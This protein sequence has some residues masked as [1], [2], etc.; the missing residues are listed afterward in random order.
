MDYWKKSLPNMYKQ[1]PEP[2]I[3]IGENG[4]IL[5][6]N[7]A[8]KKYQ[9]EAIRD[10]LP[11]ARL[12][13]L[14][15]ITEEE[16]A[17]LEQFLSR[18]DGTCSERHF[19]Y[20]DDLDGEVISWE[21]YK[22]P[23]DASSR[24]LGS[25]LLIR[26]RSESVRQQKES[27]AIRACYNELLGLY[28]DPIVIH[29][30]SKIVFINDVAEQTIGGTSEQLIGQDVFRFIHPSD[31][32]IVAERIKMMRQTKQRSNIEEIRLISFRNEVFEVETMSKM[33]DHNG[34]PAV[35]TII[36]DN[37]ARKKAEREMIHQTFHDSLSGL[38][39]R[40]QFNQQLSKMIERSSAGFN[41]GSKQISRFAVMVLDLDRFKNIN[42]SLGHAYGDVFLKEMGSRIQS[43]VRDSETLVARMGGDEFTLL[44]NRFQDEQQLALLAGRIT[45]AIQQ[46]YRLKDTDFY[47]TVSIGIAVY[48]DNGQDTVQLLKNADTAMYEVKR[49]GK[50]GY[51]F[52]SYEFNEQLQLR[53]ELENELRK[54]MEREE[55]RL[56]YQPQ[57]S[58][59]DNR[60]IG[61]EALIRWEHPTKGIISPGVFIPVAEESDLIYS[62]GEWTMREACRQMKKWHD[63]GVFF[64]SVSVNLSARQFLQ[65]NLVQQIHVILEETGLDP[66]FLVL[67]ITE[68][69]MM[70]ASH[71]I[72]ILNELNSTG[73]KISLDDFGTGYS[74]LSYLKHYPIYK[75]KIDRSFII[76]ITTDESDQAI[77][78]TII[79]MAKH[80]KMEVIAEG[81]ETKEQLDFLTSHDCKEIQGYYYCR[82]LP[83]QVLEEKYLTIQAENDGIWGDLKH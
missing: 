23:Y 65:P 80:L 35:L 6:M 77:V 7:E 50:N 67:E 4:F 49:N 34:R 73:V 18:S 71:S 15:R 72:G 75:L 16:G 60:M 31:W 19:L 30:D 79:S 22:L 12:S 61:V 17:R 83:A 59:A 55:F 74:S 28:I 53:L 66:S 82:P 5:H 8:A 42:D 70:D 39:N 63:E 11:G 51:Q 64:A 3:T 9:R 29:Q 57:I 52:Y 56:Y 32:D 76:D 58:S 48:P 2:I 54:A 14:R 24:S 26:D 46:P 41:D 62:I 36:R 27:E 40:L 33:I 78:A 38:P 68:S 69:M 44:I 20:F 45:A 21:L 10:L 47:T 13:K 25:H 1:F 43:C 81:I 37:S